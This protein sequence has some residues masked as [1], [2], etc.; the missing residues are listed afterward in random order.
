MRLA[1]RV[2]SLAVQS[3][4]GARGDKSPASPH[5]PTPSCRRLPSIGRPAVRLTGFLRGA[6]A[7]NGNRGHMQR[8][9]RFIRDES[10]ATAI[11][12]ALLAGLISVAI[13]SAAS[14]VG[15]KVST[16]FTEIGDALR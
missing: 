6:A 1:L 9:S 8:I 2:G 11:E 12:Y 13:I 10:A 7:K 15:G 3:D 4:A 14:T 16:V 5:S